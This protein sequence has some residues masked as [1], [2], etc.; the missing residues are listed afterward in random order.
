MEACLEVIHATA[1]SLPRDPVRAIAIS[2]Q[3][4]AFT[5]VGADGTFLAKAMVS[6]DSRA[7]A[8]AEAFSR[9]FGRERLYRGTGH[10]A[11]PL[12]TLFK[13]I[14]L[15]DSCP[16]VWA[17]AVKFLCFEELLQV[18]L[19]IEPAISW[20]L[21]GRT[22]L[23]DVTSHEWE[24]DIL[25]AVGLDASRLAR[26]VPSG[27]IVGSIPASVA[28][29][30]GLDEGVTV[31]AGGHDQP[32]AALGV[33]AAF[34]GKA[35]YAMGTVECICPA[36]HAPVFAEDLY[37]NNLCTYDH[38]ARDCY[39]TLAYSL[40]GGNLLTWFRDQ[41]SG[42]QCEEAARSGADPYELI[43][44]DLPLE[45]TELLVLPYFTPSGTPYFSLD[46]PGAILGLRL[47]STR[48]Q[49]L[50]GLLEG[51]CLEMR[52]NMDIL[53]RSGLRIDEYR[54]AGGGSKSPILNQLKADVLDRPLTTVAEPEAGCL[55]MA[56]LAHATRE[57]GAVADLAPRWI[58]PARV[59]EPDPAFSD[60]YS[61]KFEHYKQLYPTLRSLRFNQ[62]K[63]KV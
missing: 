7:A 48:H 32:A 36:F 30:L 42:A 25:A 29:Q 51:V 17:K 27:T 28:S 57:G 23:F 56:M 22:M 41:W 26:P 9:E 12:F 33:G 35:L 16:D 50:R 61:E 18:R 15:R 31:V 6:S 8:S 13:L 54:A 60:R 1:A 20:P 4:E 37:K 38:V 2:S 47:S 24:P 40:T 49:V 52:L 46:V 43:L 58:R 21:A 62:E 63:E 3:G 34:P 5:P 53:A 59:F 19:G 44:R 45:P 55:G 10:S 11:H 14:W 39:A